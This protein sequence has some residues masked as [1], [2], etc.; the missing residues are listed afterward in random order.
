MTAFRYRLERPAGGESNSVPDTPALTFA[1]LARLDDRALQE[2]FALAEPAVV[3]LA[4]TGAD[5][6][7][8]YRVLRQLPARQRGALRERL[9]HPGPV[10]LREIEQAQQQLATIATRLAREHA[11]ESHLRTSSRFVATA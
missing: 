7:L 5:E 4:L 10:R 1:D 3:L 6:R 11:G 9:E 2:V 8:L